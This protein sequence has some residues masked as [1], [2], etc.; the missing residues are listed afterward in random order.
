MIPQGQSNAMTFSGRMA[1]SNHY[2][3]TQPSFALATSRAA[4]KHAD[5][6]AQAA[7]SSTPIWM[8]ALNTLVILLVVVVSLCCL[9]WFAQ[10]IIAWLPDFLG[11]NQ[12]VQV[13]RS[14]P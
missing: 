12:P 11:G 5:E 14:L 1:D 13:L 2:E 3:F 9:V 4:G 8:R 7:S 10:S 6:L